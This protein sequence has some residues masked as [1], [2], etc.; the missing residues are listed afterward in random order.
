L[1]GWPCVHDEL[2]IAVRQIIELG[3]PATAAL[4]TAQANAQRSADAP[5]EREG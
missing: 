2:V 1:A 4:A 3:Q 5:C